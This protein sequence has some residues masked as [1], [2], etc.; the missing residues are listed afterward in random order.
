MTPQISF[1]IPA[2]NEE[3]D[4]GR[5]ISQIKN[6]DKKYRYEIIVGDGNS[7]DKTR[8]IAKGLGAKVIRLRKHDPKTIAS[9]RNCGAGIASG[10]IFIF[11][12]ADT[13]IPGPKKF[14]SRVISIF[15]DRNI[16]A[17]TVNLEVFPEEKIF[18]D[19]VYHHIMN[20]FIR[21]SFGTFMPFCSGQCQIVRADV[22]KKIGG[23]DSHIVHGEDTELFRRLGKIG[24][25]YFFNDLY[26]YESPRRYRK[27]GY[28]RLFFRGLYSFIYQA[29]SGKNAFKRWKRVD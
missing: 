10:E 27:V 22:F 21:L 12:D 29:I 9:G 19:G 1:I 7:V 13:L 24:R 25:L 6:I 8:E 4:I 14:V 20:F 28:I 23:Y 15:E 16:V 2:L 5:T 18:I 26:I 17:G 3:K 11:C